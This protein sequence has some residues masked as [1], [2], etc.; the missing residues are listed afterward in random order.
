MEELPLLPDQYDQDHMRLS[1][2][3]GGQAEVFGTVA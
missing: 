1:T 3:I 2:L